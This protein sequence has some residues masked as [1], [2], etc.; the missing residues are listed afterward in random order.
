[1]KKRLL[2]IM[3]FASFFTIEAISQCGLI[4]LIGEFNGWAGDHFMTRN[5]EIPD[6]FS[7]ILI[8]TASD[9]TDTS[10]FVDMKFRQDAAWAVNW[11]AVDFPT[12]TGVLNGANIPVPVGSYVVT[13][14][15]TTGLYNFE[16][17]CGDISLIGEFNAWAGDHAMTRNTEFPD[18]WT[19]TIIL[20]T[21]DD[22]STP[23]DGI[24]DLKFRQNADWVVNWGSADFPTGTGVQNGANI[25]VPVGSYYI[26]FNCTTGEYNF[27]STC[28]EI[29]IIGEFNGWAGD[30]WMTRNATNPDSFTALLVLDASSDTENAD[31]IVGVKFRQ[32]ADWTVNWGSAD[33]PTGT[34]VINGANIPVPLNITGITCDYFVT[35]NCATGEYNFVSTSGP[36]SMIGAFNNWNGDVPMN[37]DA[38][39]P[40]LWKLTRCWY[41]DSEVKFREDANWSDNWGNNTFPSGTGTPNGSN[42]PLVAGTYDV[43]FN[44][45]TYAY[46]FVANT[47]AC[48]EIGMVG[49]FNNWGELVSGVPTDVY[50]VRDPVY[51]SQF[52]IEYNFMSS[53][54][55]WFRLNAD[56]TYTNVW[57]GT[58]PAGVGVLAGSYIAVPGGKY[59][60][61]FNC[62]SNEF[63]F[64]RLG[65]SVTASKVFTMNVDG[66]LNETDWKID[67]N[68]S[69]VVEGTPGTDLI[70]VNFGVT[71]ND[72]YLYVG[73]IVKDATVDASDTV[74]FFVDGN[75]SGGAYDTC[76]VYFKVAG[77]GTV[78]V[79]EG[80]AD[81]ALIAA[82]TT[83]DTSY[84]VETGIPWAALGVTP[85]EGS[86][87]GFD[88][89]VSEND[90]A[91][92]KM[93]WN[94]GMQDTTSTSSF[95]DLLFGILSCG[96][97]SL[98]NSTIGDVILQTPTDA[99]TTYVGTYEIFEN[100]GV[101][102]RKDRQPVVTW[103]SDVFPTGTA[104]LGGGEIPATTGRYR[105]SFDCMSGDY[106][107][108]NEPTGD[109]V[110]Y[111]Q[112]IDTKPDINGLLDEY[113]LSYNSDKWVVGLVTTINNTV[114]WGA[115]WDLKN[116][117]IGVKVIDS[118]VEGIGSPWQND[119]IEFYIDGNHDADG[120][121]DGN[122]D[123]QLVLDFKNGDSLWVKADG[124][125]ITDHDS[126]FLLTADGYNVELRVAWSNISFAPGRGR[127]I[128]WSL[129]ND[130]SD[131]GSGDRDY[132][133]VWF[134]TANDWSN[135]ADLGDLQLE[136]GPY[137][138]G[139]N[140]IDFNNAHVIL[141][142]NPATGSVF[143]KTIGDVFDGNMTIYVSDMTGRTILTQNE[144]FSGS[145]S[146][147]QLNVN[148]LTKGIYFVNIQSK[149]GRRAVKKLIVF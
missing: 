66:K 26:T 88:I 140:D 61:T 110:A 69:R 104:T 97:V 117:Y 34:G 102:F 101:M 85:V 25:P 80:P 95:G 119:A 57:G 20:T 99:P 128:G 94:G 17:T 89:I 132:Q 146:L 134:G 103:G 37:R 81:I 52:S 133:T 144:I 53:T 67:Q 32:N 43:T 121:Y 33:F 106:S 16:A 145:N 6:Q 60:I 74:E 84:I 82:I 105:I 73:V 8:L 124:V 131:L 87:I 83:T 48:G 130:D 78:K 51:P 139:I 12:G 113:T 112:F 55:L 118:P 24:I 142:P 70:E 137:F 72:E 71:Y 114:T 38:S 30:V 138:D 28:G 76:D 29:G 58:F 5:P 147:V 42:I 96:C 77:D 10:G 49:D 59:F 93:A 122:F 148:D 141:F 15:C 46:N 126:K 11:G 136:G 143:I 62:K 149:D 4:S 98:Y 109:G 90:A 123:T 39:D 65:N 21:D 44:S 19:T 23:P 41:A 75:K 125:P 18:Q 92:Y 3:I 108:V 13:F 100:A 36:I 1:M 120:T 107:F 47:E 7:T 116:F 64:T 50:L 86:Q 35:F 68:I 127:T 22:T 79:V 63:H 14:N 27:Q 115:R 129:G 9:D 45:S 111:A 135:T 2:F 56:I 91:A 54:N 31:G 40:N